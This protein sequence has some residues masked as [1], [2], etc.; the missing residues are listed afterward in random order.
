[1]PYS[2]AEYEGRLVK[3]LQEGAFVSL[4]RYNDVGM[5]ITEYVE[6]SELD[7]LRTEDEE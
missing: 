5:E 7:F 4:I 6:N 2:L 1:M 3:V